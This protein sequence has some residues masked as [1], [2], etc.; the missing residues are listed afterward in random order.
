MFHNSLFK[1]TAWNKLT[2]IPNFIR[3]RKSKFF[4]YLLEN[5][6][7]VASIL[8]IAQKTSCFHLDH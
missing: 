8:K 2:H 1:P 4:P 6:F 7:I 3:N 5:V